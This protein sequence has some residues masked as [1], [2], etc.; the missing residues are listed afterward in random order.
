M[1][2]AN[3]LIMSPSSAASSNSTIVSPGA[4]AGLPMT[5]DPLVHLQ[6]LKELY[7]TLKQQSNYPPDE[8]I[9]SDKKLKAL[10]GKI[11]KLKE[12]LDKLTQNRSASSA[13]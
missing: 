3:K 10:Q 6:G 13:T 8:Q 1:F 2:Y 12:E 5:L 9:A 11:K 7:L 4:Q